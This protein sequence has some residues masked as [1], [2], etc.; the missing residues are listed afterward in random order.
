[1]AIVM[2]YDVREQIVKKYIPLVKYIASRVIMGKTKYIEYEDL[3]SYGMLGLM[4]AINK[5]DEEKGM[6]FSTYASIRIKG[7]MIDELRKISPISKGAMDKLNRYNDAVERLQK[8]NFR[9]P[10]IKEIAGELK[11]SLAEVSQIENYINYISVVSL[12]DLIFSEEDDIPLIGTVVD[13]K[14]PSPEKSL[15]EKELLEYLSKALDNLKEKD[16][17]VLSLYYYERLT[18]KEIG[19]VLN[20]SESRVCQLHSRALIHLRQELK[21][22]KYEIENQ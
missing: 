17:T 12:E 21:R 19:K 2:D 5:F 7:S 9:E 16:K 6:K 13:E 8:K 4:D 10:D 15:E 3:V 11:I 20:V 1:M 22:L 14:S 18:L